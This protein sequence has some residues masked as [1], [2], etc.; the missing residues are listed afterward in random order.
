MK[1]KGDYYKW[2]ADKTKP[3]KAPW[4]IKHYETITNEKQYDTGRIVT[5]RAMSIM[6]V[7]GVCV[8]F[9]FGFLIWG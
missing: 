8:G 1:K 7:L 2:K 4:V 3:F 9:V 5:D 6:L